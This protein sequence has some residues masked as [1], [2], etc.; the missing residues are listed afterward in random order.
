MWGTM[1]AASVHEIHYI[2]GAP[3]W[4]AQNK[5]L[6]GTPVTDM[7][8]Y[9]EPFIYRKPE[10]FLLSYNGDRDGPGAAVNNG[11]GNP[12][13]MLVSVFAT[14]FGQNLA[15]CGSLRYGVFNARQV[16]DSN[17]RLNVWG[18]IFPGLGIKPGS[19][20]CV[21]I[22]LPRSK[23]MDEHGWNT[24]HAECLG[25]D[26]ST[27]PLHMFDSYFY[28]A[29]FLGNR[30]RTTYI[31]RGDDEPLQPFGGGVLPN[32]TVLQE[33]EMLVPFSHPLQPPHDFE[34]NKLAGLH[35]VRLRCDNVRLYQNK[36]SWSSCGRFHRKTQQKS[37]CIKSCAIPAE[38]DRTQHA[39][40][41]SHTC[42]VCN[43]LEVGTA[44]IAAY[45]VGKQ[46]DAP[47]EFLQH[48]L[49][50][51]HN[52]HDWKDVDAD[53]RVFESAP[54]CQAR[55]FGMWPSN[56][57]ASGVRDVDNQADMP[58]T[59]MI[60]VGLTGVQ[61]DTVYETSW[62]DAWSSP[63]NP[64]RKMSIVSMCHYWDRQGVG[65]ADRAWIGNQSQKEHNLAPTKS[66]LEL[67]QVQLL[68]VDHPPRW[69]R[70]GFNTSD[71]QAEWSDVAALGKDSRFRLRQVMEVIVLDVKRILLQQA[72][73]E[74]ATTDA[75]RT[76][77]GAGLDI[78]MTLVSIIAMASG[79]ADIAALFLA[80]MCK[81]CCMQH[82]NMA[83]QFLSKVLTAL[84]VAAT[85]VLPPALILYEEVNARKENAK[86]DTSQVAWTSADT[87]V[88]RG[89]YVVLAAC[90]LRMTA[91]YSGVAFALV[92]VNLA[93]ACAATVL[94]CGK[95][96]A[97]FKQELLTGF[98]RLA[99]L[100]TRNVGRAT[101]GCKQWGHWASVSLRS[102]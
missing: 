7:T 38:L 26:I 23:W 52:M 36:M 20:Q 81:C 27:L 10:R 16:H 39:A 14:L 43:V 58:Y 89:P 74:L 83:G 3:V 92:K 5:T 37:T 4:T 48:Q 102:C 1:D 12:N 51:L 13:T 73:L 90:T 25:K 87:G 17:S 62:H 54:W 53:G 88:G 100:V 85:I 32:D 101:A 75:T 33:V 69:Y 61:N 9:Y 65:Y 99:A 63:Q 11:P 42:G 93:L 30:S 80:V 70:E 71:N 22:I 41:L 29:Q 55:T 28:Q 72:T 64:K 44:T 82:S 6:S 18:H 56:H 84:L 67:L 50:A 98:Q 57:S 59:S 34:Q 66:L 96:T 46:Y 19:P 77:G 79:C 68:D 86:G 76:A 2:M 47:A 49:L 91:S 94:V 97:L 21:L 78:I 8:E 35:G 95:K 40:Q 45:P 15:D 24:S 31:S 60:N